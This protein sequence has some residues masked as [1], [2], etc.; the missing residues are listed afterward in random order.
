MSQMIPPDPPD[1]LLDTAWLLLNWP[2]G[3]SLEYRAEIETE[4][5]RRMAARLHLSNEVHITAKPLCKPRCL[6]PSPSLIEI[7]GAIN[8]RARCAPATATQ[9]TTL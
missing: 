5:R 6:I 2:E 3:V 1:R 8:T 7:V 4:F 9:G